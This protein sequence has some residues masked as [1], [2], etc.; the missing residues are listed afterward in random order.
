MRAFISISFALFA[1]S[2]PL[3]AGAQTTQ[4]LETAKAKVE[5]PSGWKVKAY[6]IGDVAEQGPVA[7]IEDV[8]MLKEV[9][10]C[11][12]KTFGKAYQAVRHDE[13]GFRLFVVEFID[14]PSVASE[15]ENCIIKA[16]N[17][18]VRSV[19]WEDKHLRATAELKMGEV[20]TKRYI[21]SDV[22]WSCHPDYRTIAIVAVGPSSKSKRVDSMLDDVGF[23]RLPVDCS[24]MKFHLVC[25]RGNI[26]CDFPDD[27]GDP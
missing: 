12:T 13:D 18:P 24:D 19:D 7:T 21:S 17:L 8:F 25:D 9:A 6:Q 14:T 27:Q 4:T 26:N 16:L 11:A 20:W 10:S 22:W 5:F 2:L 15:T 1:F 23:S 3:L